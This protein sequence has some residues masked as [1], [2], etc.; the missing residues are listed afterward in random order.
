MKNNIILVVI[1]LLFCDFVYGL[2]YGWPLR[3]YDEQQRIKGTFGEYRI[4]NGNEY[5]HKGIDIPAPEGFTVK[6]AFD[7]FF[8]EIKN[9][10]NTIV[11]LLDIESENEQYMTYHHLKNIPDFTRGDEVIAGETRLGEL[12]DNNH[13][14]FIDGSIDTY[15]YNPLGVPFLTPFSDNLDP[16]IESIKFVK[17]IDE[18]STSYE[19]IDVQSIEIGEKIDI[20]IDAYDRIPNGLSD[21]RPGIYQIKI[22]IFDPD[23]TKLTNEEH[24]LIFKTG[25]DRP[26][27]VRP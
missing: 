4:Y 13:L 5:F 6:P 17:E 20:V 1:I 27:E 26:D 25:F 9:N 10:G 14:H 2:S 7:G 16:V 24:S 11:I 18:Y 8:H 21:D 23:G 19:E 12:D 3:E 22:N 15:R